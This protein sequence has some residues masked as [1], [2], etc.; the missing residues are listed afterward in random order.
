[1]PGNEHRVIAHGPELAGDAVEQL[2]MIA[3]GK[4]GAADRPG[5]QHI[6]HPATPRLGLVEHH[7]ARRVARAMPHGEGQRTELQGVAIGQPAVGRERLGGRKAEPLRLLRQGVDPELI[8]RMRADDGHARA[9]RYFRRGARVVDVRVSQPD[10]AQ[11]HA[12]LDHRLQQT[13]HLAAGIGE[14]RLLRGVIPHET[15]VLGKG[16]DR[17]NAVTEHGLKRMI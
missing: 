14:N 8:A 6:A 10:R 4:I 11:R 17:E 3:A 15:G 16:G 5:E 7:M 1:M 12:G 9:L 13:I 2:L